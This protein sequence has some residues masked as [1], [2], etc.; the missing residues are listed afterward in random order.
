MKKRVQASFL[1]LVLFSILLVSVYLQLNELSLPSERGTKSDTLATKPE[2][3]QLFTTS[4]VWWNSSWLMRN[5][6]NISNPISVLTDYQIE[7]ALNQMNF[8]YSN[9]QANGA[10]I[11]FVA[12]DS[13][14]ELSFWI[15]N[16]NS[17]GTSTIWVKIP[18][19]AAFSTSTIYMYYKS[20][21]SATASSGENTFSYF[22]DF[23]DQ[24]IGSEPINWTIENGEYGYLEISSNS[25]S[26]MR[27][28]HYVDNST[29][30]TPRIHTPFGMDIIS[31]ILEY[32]IKPEQSDNS[33][34]I[35]YNDGISSWKGGNIYFG[36]QSTSRISYYDTSYHSIYSPY[37]IGKW[38]F[39]RVIFDDATT[40]DQT[41]F[42][43]QKNPLAEVQNID[44]YGTPTKLDYF[45]FGTSTFD[46]ME[47]YIDGLRVR[48]YSSVEPIVNIGL[49][50]QNG[51]DT[52]NDYLTDDEEIIYG[53]NATNPDTDFDGLL[54]GYEVKLYFTNP[55]SN[56][57]DQD[58]LSDFYE[59]NYHNN[60]EGTS[61]F[62]DFVQT[63]NEAS[64]S[65]N[66]G[67][68]IEYMYT[69]AMGG[70][71]TREY[72][73]YTLFFNE[74][75][76]DY[77]VNLSTS[78]DIGGIGSAWHFLM[79]LIYFDNNTDTF[80]EHAG[81]QIQDGW[82][83]NTGRFNVRDNETYYPGTTN[84]VGLVRSNVVFRIQ[85]IN[86]DVYFTITEGVT[87]IKSMT[88]ND[89]DH[90]VSKLVINFG[91]NPSY[92]VGTSYFTMVDLEASFST[93]QETLNPLSN[94]TDQD[95]L[96]DNEEIQTYNTNPFNNDSDD[97]LLS[98]FDEVIIHNTDPNDIDSDNDS[99]TDYQELFIY[100]LDPL[101]D[102]N[103][104]DGLMDGEEI[105]IYGSNP[106][107]ND[108]DFDTI[109]DYDEALIYFTDLN[110]TDSDFDN[111]TDPEELFT[112]FTNATNPDTDGDSLFD[113]EEILGIYAPT[114]PGANATGYVQTNPLLYDSDS[115]FYNDSIEIDNE[116]DPNN[117][118]SYPVNIDSDGDGLL[119]SVELTLGT[120]PFDSDTDDDG[121]QDGSE[122]NTYNTNPL[123]SDT[124][125][126]SLDD[127]AE[128][129]TYHTNPL[130]ADTDSDGLNDYSE[131]VTYNTNPS[132][133]DSDYD[134]LNDYDEVITYGTDPLD[135]DTDNDNL[136]D[137]EEV[138][139]YFTNPNSSDSDQDGL[140]DHFEI[141]SLGTDPNNQ[142]TDQ[143][144][145]SDYWEYTH[146]TDPLRK[147]ELDKIF[148]R[149]LI[150]V[151]ILP[152]IILVITFS[153]RAST[154]RKREK[155]V[156]ER[157][158][159]VMESGYSFSFDVEEEQKGLFDTN[160]PDLPSEKIQEEPKQTKKTKKPT[161]S[162]QPSP[163]EELPFG[164]TQTTTAFIN[165][166]PV[167]II[168]SLVMTPNGLK[169]KIT[170]PETNE[171][172]F[173]DQ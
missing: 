123:D 171:T 114:N 141:F 17:T 4:A 61:G 94:D 104:N 80:F 102:D 35:Y 106:L 7:I 72:D 143:D 2:D 142:D 154:K 168:K 157:I 146:G 18:V 70:I 152:P 33:G 29:T 76:G 145:K 148:G 131:I 167:R 132:A 87:I 37:T 140:S 109:S 160:E 63:K 90:T 77:D 134:G 107:L 151:Y 19:V 47:L 23:E 112:Y 110:S 68:R 95:G 48:N 84:E 43:N 44:T 24:T 116:T 165:G 144:G 81:W 161:K 163:D 128:I 22:E 166:R 71:K 14:T 147:F 38:Y 139:V 60:Y 169:W 50:E 36:H 173:E 172:W 30:M 108:T 101:D 10:D 98:D 113:G 158:S 11:R 111:L 122:V 135:S 1:G 28:G 8:N 117:A 138:E 115:D 5:Q 164:I 89:L 119:D 53:T 31:N 27:S 79:R 58:G 49:F 69:T 21:V 9:T 40:Y 42:D 15:E 59:L 13:L 155:R 73:D 150:P 67:D 124:D 51:P 39:V 105:L 121:V 159:E 6:I 12:D 74:V 64:E 85:R 93:S 103:D 118:S 16:W 54:D 20:L 78:W 120:D 25:K 75:S 153:V 86:G 133:P 45:R 62:Y 32:W 100:S 34:S 3:N 41:V 52:D 149:Y 126:D 127:Y 130:N 91:P 125:G 136:D 97:D 65:F 88:I 99:L 66:F 83:A 46:E 92:T 57:T 162:T 55:L 96:L 26:G 129:F 82:T 156:K 137:W 170:N 56:D